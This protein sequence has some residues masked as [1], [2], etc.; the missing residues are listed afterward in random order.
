M[1]KMLGLALSILALLVST[2]LFA[3]G[4]HVHTM[5]TVSA[6]DSK[7]VE[8][9]TQDGKT[10]SIALTPDTK[11]VKGKATAKFADIAVGTRVMVESTKDDKEQLTA[12]EMQLG[13]GSHM[14][15][16]KH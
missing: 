6:I 5:G 3:H 2:A 4:G 8:V 12:V 14:E 10:V 11:Y 16:S 7:H 15:G 13:T 9:K 1:R